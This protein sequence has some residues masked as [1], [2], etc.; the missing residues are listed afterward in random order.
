MSLVGDGEG[1]GWDGAASG[2][3]VG[4]EGSDNYTLVRLVG[5]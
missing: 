3:R 5:L 2:S 1:G 4:G